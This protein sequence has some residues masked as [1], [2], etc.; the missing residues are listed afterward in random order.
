MQDKKT[1]ATHL[2]PVTSTILPPS[3]PIPSL[4]YNKYSF[5]NKLAK[6]KERKKGNR[7]F[8][9]IVEDDGGG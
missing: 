3:M 1:T 7:T 2:A 8:A 9:A 6:N 5:E 4:N